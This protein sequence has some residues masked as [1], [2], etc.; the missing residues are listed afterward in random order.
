MLDVV[1]ALIEKDGKYLIARR[2]T[3]TIY[4][5]GKWEFPGG[6]VETHET[7]HEAI[8]REI[9]EEFDVEVKAIKFLLNEV[10]EYPERTINLKLYECKYIGGDF[11]LHDH[12]EYK[13]VPLEEIVNYDLCEGDRGLIKKLL[14]K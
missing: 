9:K 4:S 11:V 5:Y 14:N 10:K 6:K 7:E 12:F 13:F 3:G 1:A 8:E 2:S